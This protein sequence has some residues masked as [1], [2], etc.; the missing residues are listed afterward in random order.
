MSTT[1]MEEDEMNTL[2]RTDGSALDRVSRGLRRTMLVLALASL[3]GVAVADGPVVVGDLDP[4]HPE[5]LSKDQLDQL[6]PGAKMKRVAATTGSTQFW[7][8][9]ADG[10]MVVSSDNK[11][12]AVTHKL[13]TAS[14][15]AQGT[16]HVAP[17]GRYCVNIEWKGVPTEDWCRLVIKTSD[18]YYLTRSAKGRD[19]KVYRVWINGS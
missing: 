10:T 5:T 2:F 19:E 14:V 18:G 15:T 12:G 11:S 17:E 6:M 7:T 3:A 4:L 1:F 16:W 9:D 13:L 8:N